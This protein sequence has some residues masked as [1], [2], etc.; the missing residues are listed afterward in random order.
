MSWEDMNQE[1]RRKF[2]LQVLLKDFRNNILK[3]LRGFVLFIKY[4]DGTSI[5][6][7]G[8]VNLAHVLDWA[9]EQVEK[10]VGGESVE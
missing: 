2:M 3:E 10:A 8:E 4:D 6:A 5:V 9:F 1:D 7:L